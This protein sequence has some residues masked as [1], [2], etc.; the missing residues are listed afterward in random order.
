MRTGAKSIKIPSMRAQRAVSH[1]SV[2]LLHLFKNFC[3]QGRFHSRKGFYLILDGKL[4]DTWEQ[5]HVVVPVLLPPATRGQGVLFV[6]WP[7]GAGQNQTFYIRCHGQSV[8]LGSSR[9]NWS[10]RTRP[11]LGSKENQGSSTRLLTGRW[12]LLL[13][14]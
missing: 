4:L 7:T 9:V 12:F 13:Q 14:F 10:R 1:T 2:G 11:S 5:I 8:H 3:F 6:H